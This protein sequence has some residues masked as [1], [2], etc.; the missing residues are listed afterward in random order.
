M[1]LK[2]EIDTRMTKRK[3]ATGLVVRV[4]AGEVMAG[5]FGAK[6][7]K[8]YDVI[9]NGREPHGGDSVQRGDIADGR[10]VREARRQDAEAL[11]R[12]GRPVHRRVSRRPSSPR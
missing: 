6:G 2:Q 10:G 9:G 11:S 5:D 7:D 3:F 8:R 1:L 4:N 12:E